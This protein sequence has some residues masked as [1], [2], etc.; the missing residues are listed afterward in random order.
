MA[1]IND[2]PG[3]QTPADGATVCKNS[4]W[5]Q[6]KKW[7]SELAKSKAV[8]LAQ[9]WRATNL[10]PTYETLRTPE[11]GLVMAR[12]R[13]GGEGASFNLGEV[14]ATRCSVRLVEGPEGH[15]Y[16]LG[17]DLEKARIA[18]LC[19]ALMQTAARPIVEAQI[20]DRLRARRLEKAAAAAEKTA[21]TR[22]EFFTMTRGED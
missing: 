9:L 12:G 4:D 2:S 17:R 5:T 10:N 13:V 22:V 1:S 14:A 18:A 19:D 21:A 3:S 7:I 20:L 16:A 11:I 8:D 6:R 15:A